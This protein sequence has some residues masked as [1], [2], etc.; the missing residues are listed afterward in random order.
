MKSVRKRVVGTETL[1]H[2]NGQTMTKRQAE[3]FA[4]GL[5]TSHIRRVGFKA[6]VLDSSR[7]WVINIA[8]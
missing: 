4:N 6:V 7:G 2:P 3:R 8:K 1:D 5:L